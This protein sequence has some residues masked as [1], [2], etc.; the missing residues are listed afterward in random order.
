MTQNDFAQSRAGSEA[1]DAL[2]KAVFGY[3][4]EIFRHCSD[5]LI[6]IY[7]LVLCQRFTINASDSR[8]SAAVHDHC[9]GTRRL[10]LRFCLVETFPKHGNR[11]LF[12]TYFLPPCII[13]TV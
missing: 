1:K 8:S 3:V 10:Q 7:A 2:V 12:L 13:K 6:D 11:R 4:C 9:K 5:Y